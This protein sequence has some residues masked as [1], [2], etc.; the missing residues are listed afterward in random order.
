MALSFLPAGQPLIWG[1]LPHRDGQA[2]LDLL[3]TATP[4]VLGWA[5]LPQRSFREVPLL[6]ALAGFPGLVADIDREQ[7][8][9]DRAI[10]ER[11][12]D[13]LGLAYLRSESEVGVLAPEYAA[14]LSALLQ[15]LEPRETPLVLKIEV[16]GPVSL[17]L[18][19]VDERDRP[20]AYDPAMRE[21]LLQHLVQRI[22]WHYR[23][24][25]AM[26]R[27]VLI[28]L[29]E[30]FLN[31]LESPLCPLTWEDGAELIDRV[32]IDIPAHCGLIIDGAFNWP[33]MLAAPIDLLVFNALEQRTALFEAAP[34]VAGFV[35]RGGKLGWGLVPTDRDSFEQTTVAELAGQLEDAIQTLAQLSG[36]SPERIAGATLVCQAGRLT[37]QTPA[38]AEAIVQR[39]VELA[40]DIRERLPA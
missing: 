19:V 14:G 35:E 34:A 17:A 11:G 33:L 39:C 2:A 18:Q 8:H 32:L 22:G 37:E 5:S 3:T 26:A 29:Y 16:L 20:L 31:A 4:Q 15:H 24:L 13:R 30:P 23:Q 10:A 38:Q 28:C 36:M 1:G 6:Q 25:S 9:V 27:H 40:A 7:V 12:L 21:A